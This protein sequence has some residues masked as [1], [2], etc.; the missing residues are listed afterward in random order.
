MVAEAYVK[1]VS[2]RRVDALVQSMGIDGIS[3][4][5][6]SEMTKSLDEAVESFRSRPLDQGPYRYLWL[7]ALVIKCREAGRVVSGAALVAREAILRLLGAVLAEQN[8]ERVGLLP[9]RG[10]TG[11][12]P[13]RL[14]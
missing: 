1:G 10:G 13:R 11:D 8:D 3:K 12:T 2:T 9:P 5:L 7:D 6:V 4:S 14:W